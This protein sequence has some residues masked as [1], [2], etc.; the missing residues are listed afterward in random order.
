MTSTVEQNA[1]NAGQANQLAKNAVVTAGEGG[2]IV[3]DAI[4]AMDEITNSSN[5][6]VDIIS[7][8]DEISF[9]TNL[10]ALNA[11]VEAARAGEQGRGFAVVATKVRN[12][13]QRS[14]AAAKEINELI[15][16]SVGKVGIGSKLVDKSGQTLDE[17]VDV[18]KKVGDMISEIAAASQEQ[19]TGI[20]QINQAIANMDDIT[21]R[22]AALAEEASANS[23]NLNSQ[24]MNMK[25]QVEFFKL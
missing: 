3:K 21:Q 19:T 4:S 14:A 8:I 6:I 18:V 10:L 20:A 2:S 17:I 11:S 23:E 24:A 9:Q 15:Q 12:L 5:K 25:S 7:V 16:D 1:E 13:A 22:N